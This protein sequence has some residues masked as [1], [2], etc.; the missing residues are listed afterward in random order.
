MKVLLLI[1]AVLS[2]TLPLDAQPPKAVVHDVELR[3]RAQEWKNAYNRNDAEK[4]AGF[5]TKD[6]EYVSPHVPG[7]MIRG[8]DKIKENFQ[9][10]VSM[11]GHIDSIEVI[12]GGS[13]CDLGYM[14]CKYEATN[15]GTRVSGRNVLVL[16]KINGEWLI[17]T[18]ASVVRD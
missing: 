7:L 4:L 1:V 10:G 13:S 9:R 8:R 18:H 3:R 5:Y 11:G 2:L 16:K 15:S 17:A 12:T 6:A 14:V